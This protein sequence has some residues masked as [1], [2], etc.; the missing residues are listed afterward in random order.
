MIKDR[1]RYV[2][3]REREWRQCLR[4]LTYTERIR[5][6]EELLSCGL[7]EQVRLRRS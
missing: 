5:M 4:R 1:Q 6:T 7:V 3:E 2:E